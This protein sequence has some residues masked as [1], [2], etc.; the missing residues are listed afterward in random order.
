MEP[1][2]PQIYAP[3]GWE[4]EK[5]QLTVASVSVGVFSFDC[6]SN[7]VVHRNVIEGGTRGFVFG[8]R[9]GFDPEPPRLAVRA[10]LRAVN[11]RIW[12]GVEENLRDRG[13]SSLRRLGSRDTEIGGTKAVLRRYTAETDGKKA[14]VWVAIWASSSHICVAGGAYPDEEGMKDTVMKAIHSF[15]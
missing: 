13:L 8:S 15:G 12:E 5:E 2:V 3:E 7:G 9:I 6:V 4:T 11:E 1:P 10:I 14:S